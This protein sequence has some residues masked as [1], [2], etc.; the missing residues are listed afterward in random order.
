MYYYAKKVY[1]GGFQKYKTAL[2]Y[3]TRLTLTFER[4]SMFKRAHVDGVT[5]RE[6]YIL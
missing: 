2:L 3:T 5:D 4:L 6:K 1:I